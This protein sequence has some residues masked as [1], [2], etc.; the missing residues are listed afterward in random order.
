MA[1]WVILLILSCFFGSG[2]AYQVQD[3][4]VCCT[5]PGSSP[6]SEAILQSSDSHVAL[7]P[8]RAE[9][10]LSHPARLKHWPS[11]LP[12]AQSHTTARGCWLLQEHCGICT[13][14]SDVS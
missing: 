1:A 9:A 4:H 3:Q 10:E 6:F 14:L 11:F 8:A 13:A 5:D 7:G 2:R 12:W